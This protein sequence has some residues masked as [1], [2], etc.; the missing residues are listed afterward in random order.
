MGVGNTQLNFPLYW[1]VQRINKKTN[2]GYCF[3]NVLKVQ[4]LYFHLDLMS[5]VSVRK[6]VHWHEKR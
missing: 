2:I 3:Y 4:E 6:L 5:D 1:A